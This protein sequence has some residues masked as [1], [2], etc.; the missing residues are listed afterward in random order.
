MRWSSEGPSPMRMN[1]LGKASRDTGQS[2]VPEPP[3]R[4]TASIGADCSFAEMSCV[5]PIGN[6]LSPLVGARGKSVVRVLSACFG[7]TGRPTERIIADAAAQS[8]IG[9]QEPDGRDA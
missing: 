2:R 8:L 1:G 6:S 3:E 9:A 7:I 4:I 5:E